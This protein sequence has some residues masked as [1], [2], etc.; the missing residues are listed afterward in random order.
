MRYIDATCG[1]INRHLE[2]PMGSL[3]TRAAMPVKLVDGV[4]QSTE[5]QIEDTEVLLT[6]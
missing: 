5:A 4:G 3:A 1:R 6:V 2:G